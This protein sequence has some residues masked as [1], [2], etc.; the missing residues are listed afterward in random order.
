MA[1]DRSDIPKE[2]QILVGPRRVP[3][4]GFLW[5][6]LELVRREVRRVGNRPQTGHERRL[7]VADDGPVYAVEEGVVS[8]LVHGQSSVG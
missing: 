7:D 6:L 8:D 3:A 1:T 2:S 4:G 5:D